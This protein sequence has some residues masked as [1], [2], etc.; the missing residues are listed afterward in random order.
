[1][2]S[3]EIVTNYKY[4]LTKSLFHV[5][6]LIGIEKMLLEGDLPEIVTNY[7]HC[8]LATCNNVMDIEILIS[9]R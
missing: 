8:D 6:I 1:M 5:E 4:Q 3:F 9:I 7:K 2:I